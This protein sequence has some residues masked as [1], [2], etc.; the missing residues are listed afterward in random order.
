MKNTMYVLNG[1]VKLV[2]DHVTYQN[3]GGEK[4][5]VIP[6]HKIDKDELKKLIADGHIKKMSFDE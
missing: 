2:I 6:V 5:T 1:Y 4:Y 3:K